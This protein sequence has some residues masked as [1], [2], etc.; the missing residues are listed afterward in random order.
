MNNNMEYYFILILMT[1]MGA[2]AAFFL[3]K[4]TEATTNIKMLIFNKYFY[5]GGSLYFSS[6]LLNIYILRF[7]EYS[8]VLPLTSI[9]YIWT[10]IIAG[11]FLKEKINFKK[12]LGVGFIL[13]GATLL[14][15]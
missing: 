2:F 10:M 13:L 5:I 9:T 8:I 7:L 12:K 1:V 6:A 4:A 3:K 14:V 15:M 11:V